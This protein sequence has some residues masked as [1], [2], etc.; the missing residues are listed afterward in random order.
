MYALF[1]WPA[2]ADIVPGQSGEPAAATQW[3]GPGG[4][5]RQQTREA[6]NQLLGNRQ[7]NQTQKNGAGQTCA[8]A[9]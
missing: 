1:T 6:D 9:D 7:E 3:V 8:P 5:G 4:P 2:S